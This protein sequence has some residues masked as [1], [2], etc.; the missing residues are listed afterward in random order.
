MKYI[1]TILGFILISNSIFA[2]RLLFNQ[3]YNSMAEDFNISEKKLDEYKSQGKITVFNEEK[4]KTKLAK[5]MLNS[6]KGKSKTIDKGLYE[7]EYEIIGKEKIMHHRVRYIFIDKDRFKS[8]ESFKKYINKVRQLLEVNVFKSVAMQYSM[9]YNSN[10]GGDSGWF[11]KGET[12]PD[13]F[14]NATSTNRLSDEIFEFEIPEYNGYYF[15]KKSSSK[16][17]FKEVLVLQTKIDK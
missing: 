13:F 2:Q 16:R 5:R 6:R 14:K 11:K 17:E 15:A 1:F 7:M 3:R 4:H 12:H 9:D 10:V 8:E